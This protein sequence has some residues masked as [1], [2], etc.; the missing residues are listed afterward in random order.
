MSQK[1]DAPGQDAEHDLHGDWDDESAARYVEQY[2]EHPT[3]HMTVEAAGVRPH[4][5]VVDVGCGGGEAARLAAGYATQG[6]VIGV[7]KAP[8]MIRIASEQTRTHS[9]AARIRFLDGAAEQLPLE[10][11]SASVVLAINSLHH[12]PQPETALREVLRVLA[13][14]GRF[15]IGDEE[16][17]A[18]A[19]GHGEC[20]LSDA[21]TL[22]HFVEAAGF[23]E[24]ET[25]RRPSAETVLLLLSARKPCG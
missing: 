13:P 23:C 9:G 21:Q 14:G 4:D 24:V 5:V 19:W 6:A 25:C 3:V 8:A 1:A 22:R 16:T 11:D 12:W 20:Q 10:S 7:D 17:E 15:W 2:G 18:G